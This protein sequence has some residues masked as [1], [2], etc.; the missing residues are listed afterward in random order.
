MADVE[1]GNHWASGSP[2]KTMG[3]N[4]IDRLWLDQQL[5]DENY[6]GGDSDS[7]ILV[8]IH[9]EASSSRDYAGTRQML[10]FDG[11]L[12]SKTMAVIL[13]DVKNGSW[14]LNSK[15]FPVVR[16]Q[17]RAGEMFKLK[18]DLSADATAEDVERTF[19]GTF[20]T[21]GALKRRRESSAAPS[22][23]VRIKQ[24]VVDSE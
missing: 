9:E 18:R 19:M 15:T 21:Q 17:P 7:I 4:C 3:I 24:E 6:D 8:E 16:R 13:T 23:V 5:H 12:H 2:L 14:I 20:A 10:T 1:S 11:R 22:E